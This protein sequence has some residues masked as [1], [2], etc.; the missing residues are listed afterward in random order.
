MLREEAHSSSVD[1]EGAGVRLGVVHARECGAIDDDLGANV[2]EGGGDVGF[3][4]DVQVRP[5]TRKDFE[6]R[7]REH[8]G[9]V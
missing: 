5:R 2:V 9:E 6:A 8:R 7:A 1:L 4:R 3:L